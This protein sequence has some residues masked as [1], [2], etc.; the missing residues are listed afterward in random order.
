[1]SDNQNENRCYDVI[2]MAG[3][4]GA[5]KSVCGENKALLEIESVPVVAHV[6]SALQACRYVHRILVVG[7]KERIQSAIDRSGA[8]VQ[9][10]KELILFEQW[11][12]ALDNCWKTF[13]ASL[14]WGTGEEGSLSEE[15][16]RAR[17]ND[18]AVL[19][20][21]ADIPLLTAA[22][23]D[24]FVEASDLSR[25][26]YVLGTTSEES[27]RPYNPGQ[28]VPG[29]RFENFCFKDS[30]ERQNNLHL[31]RLFRILNLYVPQTMYR[32]RYQKRWLNILRLLWH[33]IRIRGV[34]PVMVVK[35]LL[36][37]VCRF[38]DR[39]PWYPVRDFLRRFLD[40]GKLEQDVGRLLGTRFS[41]VVTSHGGAALDVDNEESLETIRCR[42]HDWHEYQK[43]LSRDR[44]SKA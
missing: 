25:Y 17:Y 9:G 4:K 10:E 14:T 28:G 24:E 11:E 21:G 33:L 23:L 20:V 40:K 22:E 39:S 2:V 19:V 36:I 42:F 44:G 35:F 18:R 6:I 7:P 16:L 34:T 15:D 26:D 43:N 27:L 3:D 30:L 29:V 31:V 1:M 5:Y 12:T 38:M 41:T 37:H 32:Y 8:A 13:L